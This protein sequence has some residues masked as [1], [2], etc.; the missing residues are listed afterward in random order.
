M[1]IV[2]SK[3]KN[4]VQ[5]VSHCGAVS[6]RDEIVKKLQNLGIEVDVYG[7][8]GNLSCPMD[9]EVCDQMLD[10]TYKFYFAFENNLC[11]DYLTEKLYRTISYFAL[12]VILSGANYTNFLPPNS[13][14]DAN[15]FNTT[16]E[17]ASHLKFLADNPSEIVKHFYWKKYYKITVDDRDVTLNHACNI[18]KKMNDP[19]LVAQQMVY[20]N[21]VQWAS[22]DHAGESSCRA[23]NII[24]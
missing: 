6:K 21:P 16:E 2:T 13:Y 3:T 8:C 23:P 19:N 10:T 11:N 24:I 14:I 5:F 12:P 18:C 17:L 4:A 22:F 7:A 15:S 20:E 9:S 1:N